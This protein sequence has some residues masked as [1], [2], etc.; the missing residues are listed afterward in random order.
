VEWYHVCWPRLTAKCVEPVVSISW[1]SCINHSA[2][3]AVI[4]LTPVLSAYYR[5]E[6]VFFLL[7][8]TVGVLV[9]EGWTEAWQPSPRVTRSLLWSDTRLEYPRS[10]GGSPWNVILFPFSA[11]TLLV[12]RQEGHSACK[13]LCVGLHVGWIDWSLHV[14]H[15]PLSLPPPSSLAPIKSRMETFCY[16]LSQVV[17]ENGWQMSV[18]SIDGIFIAP[19]Q[20]MDSGAWQCK[21]INVCMFKCLCVVLCHDVTWTV[22]DT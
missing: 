14:L 12:G 3:H 11:L 21:Y 7:M 18:Q 4:S 20:I 15:F 2:W 8:W 5:S 17:L 9:W 19:V 6:N 1:A 10:A 16:Q 22:I 13:K